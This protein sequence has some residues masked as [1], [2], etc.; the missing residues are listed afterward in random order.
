MYLN[1]ETLKNSGLSRI[2]SHTFGCG[3]QV[4]AMHEIWSNPFVPTIKA[5]A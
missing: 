1:G 5:K 3:V 4:A 2:G